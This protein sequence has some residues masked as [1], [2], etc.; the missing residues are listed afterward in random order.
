[1]PSSAQR[2]VAVLDVAADVFAVQKQVVRAC[3][4]G[5]AQAQ[6][7]LDWRLRFDFDANAAL[8]RVLGFL[9]NAHGPPG[10]FAVR[11]ALHVKVNGKVAVGLGI[12]V[13]TEG[14]EEARDV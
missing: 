2:E 4:A 13:L 12:N 6:T 3:P 1:F 11:A 14:R 8:P 5:N 9:A 10:E 7:K